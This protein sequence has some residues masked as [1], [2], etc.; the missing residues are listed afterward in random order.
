MNKHVDTHMHTDINTCVPFQKFKLATQD[1]KIGTQVIME[2][3]K[4]RIVAK[5]NVFVYL[6][7]SAD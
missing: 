2:Y 5:C 7:I 6:F 3:R 1:L 4:T